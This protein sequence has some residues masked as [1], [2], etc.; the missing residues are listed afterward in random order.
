MM[1]TTNPNPIADVAATAEALPAVIDPRAAHIEEFSIGVALLDLEQRVL[2]EIA[3]RS[4]TTT[5]RTHSTDP[6]AA[7]FDICAALMSPADAAGQHTLRDLRAFYRP[8][9][10]NARRITVNTNSLRITLDG[11]TR[12]WAHGNP[13]GV[14]LLLRR[15]LATLSTPLIRP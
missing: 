1:I 5:L 12:A 4:I 10:L 6:I 11:L 8:N 13:V 15:A 9:L 14:D 3:L 7:T 2:A